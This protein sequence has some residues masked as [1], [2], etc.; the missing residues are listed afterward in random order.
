MTVISTSDA[1]SNSASAMVNTTVYSPESSN[2]GR[3][4]NEPVP[5]SLSVNAQPSGRLSDTTPIVR[6]SPSGS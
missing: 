1:T 4:S 2:V 5:S 6:S 3:H